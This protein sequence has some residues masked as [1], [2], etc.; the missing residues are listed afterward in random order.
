M[1]MKEPAQ[2][3]TKALGKIPFSEE[4]EPAKR[5]Q[6][7]GAAAKEQGSRRQEWVQQ[8]GGELAAH[9]AHLPHK[10]AE[11]WGLQDP[12]QERPLVVGWGGPRFRRNTGDTSRPATGRADTFTVT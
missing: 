4:K 12:R 6:Q 9:G 3:R 7:E 5:E 8:E 2:Q 1:Q 10:G 11:P